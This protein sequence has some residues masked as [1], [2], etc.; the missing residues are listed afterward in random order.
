MTTMSSCHEQQPTTRTYTDVDIVVIHLMSPNE[1]PVTN[2]SATNT[3]VFA[4]LIA[5][6]IVSQLHMMFVFYMPLNVSLN[7]YLALGVMATIILCSWGQ[8]QWYFH[9]IESGYICCIGSMQILEQL[10]NMVVFEPDST[11]NIAVAILFI[12]LTGIACLMYLWIQLGPLDFRAY[13]R[14]LLYFHMYVIAKSMVFS[15]IVG[16]MIQARVSEMVD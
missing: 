6:F 2:Q 5:V 9:R 12:I 11:Y 4:F 15:M 7:M 1:F 16:Y 8:R 10:L 14:A 3:A 13:S